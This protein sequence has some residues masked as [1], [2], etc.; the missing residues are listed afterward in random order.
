MLTNITKYC[1]FHEIRHPCARIS[2]CYV[3]RPMDLEPE[4]VVFFFANWSAVLFWEVPLVHMVTLR[5]GLSAIRTQVAQMLVFCTKSKIGFVVQL[6]Q[7]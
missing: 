2:I 4:D 5:R 6:Q 7:K 3:V 1:Q